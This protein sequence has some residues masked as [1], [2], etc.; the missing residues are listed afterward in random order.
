MADFVKRTHFFDNQF[1][2]AADLGVEQAYHIG[3]RRR[4]NTS[5]H[6]WGVVPGGLEVHFEAGATA[7]TVTPG[8]AIDDQGREIVLL[9]PSDPIDLSGL[10]ADRDVHV[11]IA[12][13][14]GETDE[15][16]ETGVSGA[17][18]VTEQPQLGRSTDVPGDPGTN[19]VLGVVKRAGTQVTGVEEGARRAV[20]VAAGALEART[21]RLRDDAVDPSRWV[22]LRLTAP[23]LAALDGGLGIGTGDPDPAVT[24]DVRGPA[25]AGSLTITD[26]GGT[27]VPGT[28]IGVATDIEGDSPWLR[29]A[30]ATDA[31][32]QR[33]ALQGDRIRVGGH[34]GI[35]AAPRADRPLVVSGGEMH[36]DGGYSFQDRA[37]PGDLDALGRGQRWT[38]YAQDRIARMWTPDGGDLLMLSSGGDLR[39]T[40]TL[41]AGD[42]TG[43]IK[44]WSTRGV[45][46]NGAPSRFGRTTV[47]YA[48]AGFTEVYD[49][50]VVMQG[51]SCFPFDDPERFAVIAPGRAANTGAIPQHAWVRLDHIDTATATAFVQGYCSESDAQNEGDNTMLFLLVMFGR[52]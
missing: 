19:L 15:S 49:A 38:L 3:M 37:S 28:G 52:T 23:G 21:V 43:I 36:V 8:T 33:L 7:I 25:R 12:Y 32:V 18:R 16:A 22:T 51:F 20:G 40:G 41:R 50:F 42:P 9:D 48:A 34:V 2:R 29:I 39:V 46:R 17:T 24:L 26:P 14:E 11:F 35:G 27:P 6:T 47:S 5:L 10:P 30:G 31:G 1:L 44:A 45:V 4:L 13:R